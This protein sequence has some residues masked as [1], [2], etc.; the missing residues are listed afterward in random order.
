MYCTTLISKCEN[1]PEE[2]E[3][4]FYFSEEL[5]V[6]ISYW[7]CRECEE[8]YYWTFDKKKES[9]GC[10]GSCE[11][12]GPECKHCNEE[13]CLECYDDFFIGIDG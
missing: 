3:P 12:Y 6:E 9:F 11:I 10:H 5:D 7:R 4:V 1:L 13:K 8:T 2:Y